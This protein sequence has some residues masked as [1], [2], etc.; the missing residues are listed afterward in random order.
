MH[1]GRSG[2]AECLLADHLFRQMIEAGPH[3]L[4]RA[5]Q[6]SGQLPTQ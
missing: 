1:D 2:P 5:H 3:A 4:P 6:Q